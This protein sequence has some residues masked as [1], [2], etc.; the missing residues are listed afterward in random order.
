M[1]QTNIDCVVE[2]LMHLQPLLYKNIL[3]PTRN[4]NPMAPGAVFVLWVLKK[5][6]IL[7]MS[8]I[9]R[10]LNMPKPHVTIIIDK[11][12]AEDLVERIND[13]HDRRIVN[14]QITEKGLETLLEIKKD[15]SEDLR[16][17]LLLLDEEKLEILSTASQQVK[18][19]LMILLEENNDKSC[20]ASK[21][22]QL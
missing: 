2:N 19:I 21:H 17:K 4:S 1:I 13:P 20:Q 18:D 12:I 14:I 10:K 22:G 8:E 6:T 15:T 3:K 9:G 5:F 7:S 11:L 16:N